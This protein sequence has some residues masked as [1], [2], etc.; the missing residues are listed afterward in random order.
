MMSYGKSIDASM[1]D[2][3]EGQVS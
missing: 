1:K 3:F 2:H